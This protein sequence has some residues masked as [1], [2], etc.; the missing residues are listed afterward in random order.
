MQRPAHPDDFNGT[1]VIEWVNVS[2]GFEMACMNSPGIYNEGFAYV[3]ASVQVNGLYGFAE[4]P[5]GLTHWDS[6]RYGDLNISDDG[7]SY[8][9]FTQISRAV[10][11]ER[12]AT[13]ID[14]MGGLDVQ[15][16]F[17]VGA[18]QSG[19][20]VFSYANGVQPIEKAFD[21][22][23]PAVY[24][25]RGTDFDSEIAHIKEGGKT[26]VRNVSARIRED[27]NCKVFII[28]SQ[29]EANTLGNL[30]QPDSDTIVSWQVA[31][32]SH[33]PPQRMIAIAQQCKRDGIAGLGDYEP[34]KLEPTD[35]SYVCEAALIRIMDWIDNGKQPPEIEPL[36]SINALFGYR[37]DNRGNVQGGVRL[38]EI[39]V[40]I[41]TYDISLLSG[42]YG[43]VYA[44]SQNEI[45]EL[46]P[47]HQAYI[48]AV[49]TAANAAAAQGIMLPYRATE[50]IEA[51]NAA[52]VATLWTDTPAIELVGGGSSFNV[53]MAIF[54]TACIVI[55]AI[56]A[57]ICFLIIRTIRKKRT[58][59]NAM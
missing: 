15:K 9:I 27:I 35:W 59:K 12:D 1:V 11:K 2:G 47:T 44:F 28:N 41:A 46:Y 13:E 18:S 26:K 55:A 8:D 52:W 37:L 23:V 57:L 20:R 39:S 50:Y 54:I 43:K 6:A 31:G 36:S 32:S 53:V 30:A 45:L 58:L 51:A 38:P 10:G 29:T 5:M 34:N 48:D 19:S 14:P 33:L 25:G 42:L 40:P 24:A 17:A 7:L 22:I 3:L 16:V 21:A 4:N 49:T 56:I